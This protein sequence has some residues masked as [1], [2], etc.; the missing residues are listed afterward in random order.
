VKLNSVDTLIFVSLS[1]PFSRR[2]LVRL[3]SVQPP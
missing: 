3:D 1:L 2:H